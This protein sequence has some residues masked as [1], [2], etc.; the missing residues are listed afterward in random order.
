MITIFGSIVMD[1]VTRVDRLPRP[2]E[3]RLAPSYVLTPGGKGANQALA[4][5]RAGADVRFV[6]STGDDAFADLVLENLDPAGVTLSGLRRDPDQ[7]TA[8]ATVCV[9]DDGENQIVVAA[10]ANMTTTAAQLGA[11]DLGE[12][13]LLLLQMEIRPVQNWRALHRAKASGTTT[14]LNVAPYAAVPAEALDHLDILCLNEVEAD[15]MAAEMG[16]PAGDSLAFA[17]H[18]AQRH[19][20]VAVVTLGA[21]GALLAAG[22]EALRANALRL[23]VKDTVGAGDGFVGAFAAAHVKGLA[24]G[25]CL[26]WGT[27][28]GGLACLE[29]GAQAGLPDAAAIAARLDEISIEAAD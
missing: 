20:L 10:G 16:Q 18:L 27:V 24:P 25:E 23:D 4:A 3:S 6:G 5:A 21:D 12:G 13:R 28:A 29:A 17:R 2:G 14:M 7:P 22:G 19:E 1:V 8:C 26:R 9:A 15:A 11:D